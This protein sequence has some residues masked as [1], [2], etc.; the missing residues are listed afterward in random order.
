MLFE[1]G[2]TYLNRYGDKCRVVAVLK[3][4]GDVAYV[5]TDPDTGE[6]ELTTVRPSGKLSNSNECGWDLLKVECEQ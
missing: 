3:P 6:E 4:S 1:V 2:K 5:A